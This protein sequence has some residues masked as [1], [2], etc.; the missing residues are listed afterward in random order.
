[1]LE[2][3]QQ[4]IILLNDFACRH[5]PASLAAAAPLLEAFQPLCA[6]APMPPGTH[7]SWTYARSYGTV[8][9][10]MTLD[11]DGLGPPALVLRAMRAAPIVLALEDAAFLWVALEPAIDGCMREVELAKLHST[12]F[13]AEATPINDRAAGQPWSADEE[14]HICQRWDDGAAMTEIAL[15]IG[16]TPSAILK[17]MTTL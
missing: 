6:D 1:M 14:R 11:W 7:P 8:R 16:R 17:R 3:P 13:M 9:W 5:L 2:A 12:D 4:R 15:E 10:S